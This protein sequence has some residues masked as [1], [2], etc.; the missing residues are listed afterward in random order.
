MNVNEEIKIP[1]KL[2][3]DLINYF[4]PDD[5]YISQ[6]VLADEIRHQIED[7]IQKITNRV[8]FTKYKTAASSAERERF[9]REYLAERGISEAFISDTE[10]HYEN[11]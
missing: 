11:V 5:E 8:L 9:R 6:D 2:F 7:K 1:R 4:Y 3:V 10:K